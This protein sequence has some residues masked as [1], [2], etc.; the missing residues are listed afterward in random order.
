MHSEIA[1]RSRPRPSPTLRRPAAAAPA[2]APADA[3]AA[4]RSGARTR[5]RRACSNSSR[6]GAR[7]VGRV[8]RRLRAAARA[9]AADRR[10][11]AH[12]QGERGGG[13]EVRTRR[14]ACWT[15]SLPRREFSAWLST[16]NSRT[17]THPRS[18]TGRMPLSSTGRC[19]Q[20]WSTP[21]AL[22][23]GCGMVRLR[24]VQRPHH[25]QIE[26]SRPGLESVL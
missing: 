21:S 16:N 10:S 23:T 8:A 18:R 6:G 12:A 17:T 9:A 20:S 1:R 15:G 14:S 4:T 11:A 7:R 19:V 22:A 3:A 2:A 25:S 13:E 5:G 24:V 26:S